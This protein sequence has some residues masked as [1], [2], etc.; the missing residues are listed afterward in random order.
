MPC[1]PSPVV[2]LIVVCCLLIAFLMPSVE[3]LP[4][5]ISL[6]AA[7]AEHPHVERAQPGCA[8]LDRVTLVKEHAGINLATQVRLVPW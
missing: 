3:P 1:G 5:S 6:A 8:A 2:P 4:P 7:A